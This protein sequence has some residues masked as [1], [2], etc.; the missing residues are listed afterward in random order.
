MIP[1]DYQMLWTEIY[2][3]VPGKPRAKLI[4]TGWCAMPKHELPLNAVQRVANHFHQ[5]YPANKYCVLSYPEDRCGR[6]FKAS[7]NIFGIWG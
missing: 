5:Q 2:K 1:N 7:D 3:G 6:K 4:A